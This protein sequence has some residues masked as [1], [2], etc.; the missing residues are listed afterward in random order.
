M[1]YLSIEQK[2][3]FNEILQFLGETLDITKT[4]FEAAVRSYN[5]VGEWL[6]RP[7]SLLFP[8]RP[9][10]LAQGSFLLGTMIQSINPNDDL[11]ID[12]VCK[13]IGKKIDWTQFDV[14][15]MVGDELKK[16]GVYQG[17]V[18]LPD[19]RR[20]WTLAYREESN[21]SY[22]KYH[23]DIL[24]SVVDQGY[25]ILM[26]KSLSSS[27]L[28]DVGELAIR[29]TDK[30]RDDYYS[31]TS[32]LEWLKT[33]PFGYGKW[34]FQRANFNIVKGI[35]LSESVKPVPEYRE[36][37]LP[38]QR[39]VQILKRHRDMMFNG[40][41]N[42]PISIIITTLAAKAYNGE[43]DIVTGL[44][45][46]VKDMPKYIGERYSSEHGKIIKW[47]EN[48]VNPE[49]NFADKW[50]EYP[51]REENFY[52][53]H[54][55]VQADL[56]E[57]GNRIGAGI[58]RLQEGFSKSFGSEIAGKAF[59]QYGLS[60]KSKRELGDLKIARGTGILGVTRGLPVKN[61]NFEGNFEKE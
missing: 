22:D 49:E 34:F 32:H 38:L 17:L 2:R 4:Q 12:L 15:K 3:Q 21:N 5:A 50:P 16:H 54:S 35:L 27:R 61:H 7:E 33:N 11:D 25:K 36:N 44:S 40:D 9:E 28:E 6:S 26:E 20:C 19:G 43:S 52:K 53:W 10:I 58:D 59:K 24:P 42:K 8:F 23:M 18:E 45:N 48:P 39:I 46:V 31:Q 47:I 13:L 1:D 51:K 29:I 56:V 37:K 14:K 57:L 60:M 30:E 55:Q 41:E